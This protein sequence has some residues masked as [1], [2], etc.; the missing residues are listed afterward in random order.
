MHIAQSKS[1]HDSKR[2][3]CYTGVDQHFHRCSLIST[4]DLTHENFVL[5]ALVAS[6]CMYFVRASEG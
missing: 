3:A 4:F 5:V 2:N 6:E 1:A